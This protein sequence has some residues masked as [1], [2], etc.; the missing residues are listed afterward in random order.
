[1][2]NVGVRFQAKW[3]EREQ[4]EISDVRQGWAR[5]S[6]TKAPKAFTKDDREVL[7]QEVLK[8]LG[9]V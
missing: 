4:V 5:K 6:G 2:R 1:M 9:Y 7:E 3:I 8:E